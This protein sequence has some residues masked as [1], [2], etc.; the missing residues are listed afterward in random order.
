MDKEGRKLV[1]FVEEKG[2]E[3][4]NG[5]IRGD[6]ER[7]YMYTGAKGNTVIDYFI[8]SKEVKEN[9]KELGIG[10]KMD[11]AHHPV[12]VVTGGREKWR[13]EGKKGS[14]C[15]RKVWDG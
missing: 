2:W 12:K 13:G 6:E 11:S 4:F 5:S 7:E 15:W 3:I 1:K 8:G 9:I 10:D 14:R